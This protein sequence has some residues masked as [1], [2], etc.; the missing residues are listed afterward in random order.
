M[1]ILA[2]YDTV[3]IQTYIY[4]S[5]RLKDNR[6]ASLLV[7]ECF[8]KYLNKAVRQLEALGSIHKS[9]MN[10][11]EKEQVEFLSDKEVD[12]EIIYIGGGNVLLY[13]RD[14]VIYK[15]LNTAFSSILLD[16]I[17]GLTVMTEMLEIP[18][19]K[20]DFGGDVDRLFQ[21]LQRK[22]QRSRGLKSA[23]CLSVT[24][25]CSYTHAPAVALK[26]DGKWIS[27]ELVKKRERGEIENRT[28]VYKET[29]DMAGKEGEQWIAVVH[30]DG[31]AM[32]ENI[33]N[34][35]KKTDY[36]EGISRIRSF[37][38]GIAD[39]YGEAY[40]QTVK[41][42]ADRIRISSDDRLDQ[43]KK[44]AP[45][46][47]IYGAG[48]DLT[49]IC[50]G[51]LGIKS[52]ELFMKNLQSLTK[53][54]NFHESVMISACAGIAFTKPGYP[55]AR[56][57]KIAE[58]CCKNAKKKARSN[59]KNGRLGNYLDF[60]IVRGSLG[61]LD[62]IRK[63]E[64]QLLANA[65]ENWNMLLRPYEVVSGDLSEK[66]NLNF[67]YQISEFIQ[68]GGKL[69]GS[70]SRTKVARSKIKELRNAYCL[71]KS[72]ADEAILRLKRRYKQEMENL[73]EIIGQW[74]PGLEAPYIDYTRTVVLWDALE[75][76]DIYIGL[77]EVEEG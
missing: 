23:P 9:Y 34:L 36:A 6:G 46:R 25:E 47:K 59:Q 64:Y 58:E 73:E 66:G 77:E 76:M 41:E 8:T 56:A 50:Y 75:M 15:K 5:N 38:K 18:D 2:L 43:Y 13:L 70:D 32:G 11:E 14:A 68:R 24:R 19:E 69:S 30:I 4:Q 65:D 62:S 63:R 22:K 21:K 42:C 26:E 48:D 37:A 44:V 72:E 71:G 52:S 57:Y 3:S 33:R 27:S 35:L 54:K 28:D 29:E 45:F 67:F 20:V 74:S 60:Q 39:L 31:N 53:N 51:P 55:F 10:W 61:S 1:G 7:E 12:C 17:P 16:E 49:F 40:E